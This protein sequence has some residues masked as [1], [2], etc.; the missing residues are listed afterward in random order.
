MTTINGKDK[1]KY[2]IED[3]IDGVHEVADVIT[4]PLGPVDGSIHGIARGALNCLIDEHPNKED[5]Y[6]HHEH[7]ARSTSSHK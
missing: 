5:R 4:A 2:V 6:K 3:A 7:H 1:T